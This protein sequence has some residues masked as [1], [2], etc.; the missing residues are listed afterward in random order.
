MFDTASNTD[1][2]TLDAGMYILTVA[3]IEPAEDNGFGPSVLWRFQ[4]SEMA[5]PTDFKL[6]DNGDEFLFWHWTSTKMTPRARARHWVEALMGRPLGEGERIDP[7]ALV[8]R[9]MQAMV[10]H[11]EKEGQVRAKVSSEVRPKAYGEAPAQPAPSV[12]TA[13]AAKASTPP[14]ELL[15][16]WKRAIVKAELLEIPSLGAWKVIDPGLL[17][18][19]ELRAKLE[20][21][22]NLI[23]AA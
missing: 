17:T 3:S 16:Q 22:T 11:E 19:A 14:T 23:A 10:I 7:D 1:G 21:M 6:T 5:S 4:V 20:Q 13:P 15:A 2:T 9:R 12:S 18:P 8:G